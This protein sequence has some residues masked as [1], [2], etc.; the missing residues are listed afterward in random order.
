MAV[1]DENMLNLSQQLASQQKSMVIEFQIKY[2]SSAAENC[3]LSNPYTTSDHQ[4]E[5]ERYLMEC[6]KYHQRLIECV[7]CKIY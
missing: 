4:M 1:K 7:R 3:G 2:G 5:M 6:I